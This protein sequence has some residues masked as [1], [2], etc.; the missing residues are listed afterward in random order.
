M[1]D[2][3]DHADTNEVRLIPADEPTEA[4][5]LLLARETGVTYDVSDNGETLII[6][7][8]RDAVDFRIASAPLDD[9]D[10][11]NWTDLV[12]HKA[13]CLIVPSSCSVTGWSVWNAKRRCPG[14]WC[15]RLRGAAS[16]TS[17]LTRKPD[18][19]L[20][21]GYEY[22]T[23]FCGFLIPRRPRRP[24][25]SITICAPAPGPFERSRKS[26]RVMIRK[27]M[28]V[29]LRAESHDGARVP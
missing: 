28:S 27:P 20:M 12:P 22:E 14:S 2:A 11:T 26:R 17:R 6:R 7:T 29:A 24:G 25:Y 13:G 21:L 9:P 8:N 16:T 19:S 23:I 5:R 10:P 4:P 15:D 18:L 3:H 1:I